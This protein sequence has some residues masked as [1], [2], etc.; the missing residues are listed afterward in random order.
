[1]K[2]LSCGLLPCSY[3]DSIS[4]FHCPNLNRN[5]NLYDYTLKE[6]GR[7]KKGTQKKDK[8]QLNLFGGA[9]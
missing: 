2:D 1:M 4:C 8:T 9:L 6:N 3:P 7:H 5:A